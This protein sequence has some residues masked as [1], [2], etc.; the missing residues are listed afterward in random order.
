MARLPAL[1]LSRC[2]QTGARLILGLALLIITYM[3]L[4]PI[5]DLLQ[6]TVNDKFGH[7]LAF[8]LLAFL[9][10]ASWPNAPF[11]W[12]HGAPL[13]AYGAFLECAQYFVPGRFFS[14]LDIVADTVGIGL[15]LFLLP[16][17]APLIRSIT[18]KRP[19]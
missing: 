8:L 11:G 2:N 13:V 17:L 9:V 1:P 19:T 10:H 15:Y 3:A 4:T 18:G 5:P 14:L 7:A 12:R 6:Q 16:L